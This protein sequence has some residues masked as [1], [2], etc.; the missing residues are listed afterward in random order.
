MNKV[1]EFSCCNGHQFNNNE[2]KEWKGGASVCPFCWSNG[3]RNKMMNPMIPNPKPSFEEISKQMLINAEILM[4]KISEH[5]DK[6]I[7]RLK[8]S[9]SN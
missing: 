8:N 3:F 6:E 9:M 5:T 1:K 2:V 4:K 7:E